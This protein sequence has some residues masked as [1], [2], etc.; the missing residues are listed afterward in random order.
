MFTFFLFIIYSSF[1]HNKQ[2]S[3]HTLQLDETEKI[4]HLMITN[5]LDYQY[6]EIPN[7]YDKGNNL[8]LHIYSKKNTVNSVDIINSSPFITSNVS[9]YIKLEA[10]DPS[11]SFLEY[12][13]SEYINDYLRI[14]ILDYLYTSSTKFD[15]DINNFRFCFNKLQLAKLNW[16]EFYPKSIFNLNLDCDISC[17]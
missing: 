17:L 9:L 1:F 7:P 14:Q 13:I 3:A 15:N 4:C 11:L 2:L 6:L 8:K 10:F 12:E 5:N 16:N